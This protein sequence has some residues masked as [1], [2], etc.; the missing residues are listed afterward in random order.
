[1]GDTGSAARSRQ[2]KAL[3]EVLVTT[4]E[5]VSIMLARAD[6]AQVFRGIEAIIVDEWHAL[7]GSKRGTQTELALAAI[8]RLSPTVRIWAMSATLPNVEE[9]ARAVVGPGRT[10]RIV[11]APIERPIKV[12][13]LLPSDVDAFPW[14]GHLGLEMA[15]KVVAHLDIEVSTLVFTN[16]RNQAEHWYQA[17]Q[18]ARPEWGARVAVHHSAVDKDERARIEGG[19]NDGSVN[20]VVCT[21]SLDLGVDFAPVARVVNIGSPKGVA[22]LIQRAGRSGHRP[23]APCEVLC[24]P[25]HALELVEIRAA[26]AAIEDGLVEPRE[27]LDAPLDV[28]AQHMVTRALG[29]GFEPDALFDEVRDTAAYQHL[30]RERFGW[31]LSLVTEGGRTL[32]AY[33]QYH[34]VVAGDDGVYRVE[35]ARIA[36]MH[37]MS[38]GTIADVPSVWVRYANGQK[39]GAV[40]ETFVAR[41]RPGDRFVFAGKL[42]EFVRLRDLTCVVK[43]AGGRP[44]I[45]PRWMGAKMAV[46]T[47]LAHAMLR[48]FAGDITGGPE[49]AA[50]APVLEAQR[51]LSRLPQ[52]GVV[53][54]EELTSREGHH[55]FLY[56]FGGRN[57]H[58]GLAALLALRLGR[59]QAATFSTSV[60]DY[61]LE[62]VSVD[63]FPFAEALADPALWSTVALVDDVMEAINLGELARRQFRDVARVAG[64]VFSGYPGQRKT[65]KQVQASSGLLYDVFCKYDP[66]NLL[67]HQA[68]REV[69]AQSFE[70]DRLRA[71]LTALAADGVARV[72]IPRPT[73]LA[74]PLMVSR[75]NE[76]VFSTESVEARVAK[77][78]ADWGG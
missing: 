23:G 39:L 59:R 4:P 24:V 35:D 60:N 65:L 20:I 76:T 42:L 3:P 30:D 56:P 13:C 12:D 78:K 74:F 33:P 19:L 53:L 47:H 31:C 28:L 26:R 41:M 22:R 43:P 62:L 17:I 69:L 21:T 54:A 72:V 7:L 16:T 2:R 18:R 48:T 67:L 34:K 1:T 55:L 37:R 70:L 73:P 36:R 57:A 49:L 44:T 5:S 64:L 63:P 8:R 51:A 52:P 58:E 38:I 46:S 75:I 15:R 50:A 25:T 29:G 9:A 61:G 27:P 66:D 11:T 68:Q 40:E 77:M 45:V 32:R 71:T 14:A 10:A 6:A